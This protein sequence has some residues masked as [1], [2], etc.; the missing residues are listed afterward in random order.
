MDMRDKLLAA[1]REAARQSSPSLPGLE[2]VARVAGVSPQEVRDCLGSP[3]NFEALLSWQNPAHET[4]LKILESAMRVFG[5]KGF[6]KATLDAV[7]ADAGMTKGAIYWHFKSKNDLFFAMLDHR[8]QQDTAGPLRGDMEEL[9]K[10]AKDPLPAMTQ[11]F[12]AGF[13]RVINDPEWVQLHIECLSLGRSDDVR[14][15]F[16]TFYDQVWAMSAGLS[17]EL[18][19]HDLLSRDVDPKV[20]AIFWSAL[21]DGLVMAW[22]IKGEQ[23]DWATLIPKIFAMVW[24]GMTPTSLSEKFFNEGEPS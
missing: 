16:S 24:Q 14:E 13:F 17:Q 2:A 21:F 12:A 19:D 18:K 22:S 6:Q 1:L 8:F 7:A 4:R 11:M 3:E 5:R 9:L 15:R 10:Q 23:I 20:A